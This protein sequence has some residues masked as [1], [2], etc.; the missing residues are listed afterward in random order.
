[1]IKYLIKRIF[2]RD[3]SK[4]KER[5]VRVIPKSLSE[6]S[7]YSLAVFVFSALLL[8]FLITAQTALLLRF[9]SISF[10]YSLFGLSFSWVSAEAWPEE[11]IFLVYGFGM[12][13]YFGLGFFLL[14]I[15]KKSKRLHWKQRL[16]YTWMAFLMIHTLPLGM[17]SGIFFFDGFG[18]AYFWLFDTLFVRASLT[19]LVLPFVFIQR[20]FWVSLFLK[21]ANSASYFSNTEQR[22]LLIKYI[23]VRPWFIG[24]SLLL[25]IVVSRFSWAWFIFLIG[26]GLIVLPIFGNRISKRKY[27][28]LKFEK[29]IFR[30]PNPRTRFAIIFLLLWLANFF[31]KINF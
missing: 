26:L 16:F 31:V 18:K 11:R 4:H 1:M 14:Y 23:F 15:L 2:R 13:V 19:V 7:L 28:I 25:L 30:Y 17:L 22:Q 12:L 27:S 3:K 5:V 24:V 29:E 6:L 9:F 21:A 20:S 10:S 8:Q